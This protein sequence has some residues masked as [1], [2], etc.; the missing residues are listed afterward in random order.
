MSK[1]PVSTGDVRHARRPFFQKRHYAAIAAVLAKAKQRP[2]DNAAECLA[3]LE[4]D[5]AD[6]FA[7]D[8]GEFKPGRFFAACDPNMGDSAPRLNIATAITA[9]MNGGRK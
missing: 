2:N 7:A 5:F 8:N 3:D 6:L 1:G 4:Q 9:A